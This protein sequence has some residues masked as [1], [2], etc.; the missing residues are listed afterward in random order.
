MTDVL[1]PEQRHRCMSHIHGKDTKP[2]MIVRKY[3]FAHGFRYRLH[4]KRLPGTP[5]IVLPKYRTV[6]FVNGCFWHGH[7]GCKYSA[8]PVKNHNFWKEKIEGNIQRDKQE[9][10]QL[11]NMGWHTIIIWQCQLKKK[12]RQDYLKALAY[13]INKIFLINYGCKDNAKTNDENLQIAAEEYSEYK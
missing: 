10:I 7:E 3:L 4:V 6:I 8:L 11:R 13:T 12:V 9:R 1:T 2:E 5:D